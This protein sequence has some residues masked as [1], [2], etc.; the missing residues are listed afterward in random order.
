[1]GD[2][3]ENINI[4]DSL[5]NTVSGVLS[6]PKGAYWVV[7]FSHG[8]T[9]STNQSFYKEMEKDLNSEGVATIR[10]DYYGHGK[11]YPSKYGVSPDTTL[12]KAIESLIAMIKYARNKG[13]KKIGLFG[14]SFGGVVSLIAA[15]KEKTGFLILRS[16]VVEPKKF[17]RDRIKKSRIDLKNWQKLGV[18]H[19]RLGNLEE[20]KLNWEFWTDL[21]KYDTLRAAKKMSCPV[22]IIHG[23]S[24]VVVPINQARKLGKILNTGVYVINGADHSYTN[25][26]HY[27][28]MK[29]II[30]EFIIKQTRR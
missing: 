13:F 21:Q 9:S 26:K 11:N 23:D 12:S 29:S 6:R 3:I 22:L 28:E 2:T 27:T 5:G 25:P 14:S 17:W 15:S 1:M 30:R 24:D 18:L 7:I 10:Y 19:Y 4:L 20:F 16:A 8:F